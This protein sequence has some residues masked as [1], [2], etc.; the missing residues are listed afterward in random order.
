V[1]VDDALSEWLAAH[2]G[3][4][5]AWVAE[6]LGGGNSNVTLLV[7]AR[8]GRYVIRRPPANT[9]SPLAARGVRREYATLAALGAAGGA[10]RAPRAVGFCDDPAVIGA[11]F[12]VVTQMPGVAVTD[13]LPP[14][15]PPGTGTLARV[16]EELVDALAAV[17]AIDWRSLDLPDF[18]RPDGFL[19][20]QLDRWLGIRAEDAVRDLPAFERIAGVLRD[21]LPVDGATALV[22]GD[23][24]LDNTLFLRDAPQ[25]SAIIDWEL[26]TFGDP[27]LDVGLVLAFWGERAVERP[28]FDFV[29][30]VTRR[31]DVPAREALAERWARGSG[32][33]LD[34]LPYWCAF[35]LWRLAA[36]VEGAYCLYRRGRV[37]SDYARN[38]E[39]DVPAL[40]AE[41]A[42]E[43]G[44]DPEEDRS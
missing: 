28:G 41:A 17:H 13:A 37:D 20:R 15:W 36:M 16:G 25:L 31:P 34:D 43:L 42:A 22:H 9:I 30:A 33:A 5:D 11:P 23:F 10:V 32:H 6:Q 4:E 2:L 26:A 14:D 7:E 19:E 12:A 8:D 40:L 21:R 35:A 3:I 1:V 39:F 27:R 18:S 24:H 29:Q 44:L 38:L